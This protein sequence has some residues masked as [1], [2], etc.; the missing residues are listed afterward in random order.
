MKH[1]N[2]WNSCH[3]SLAIFGMKLCVK[4]VDHASLERLDQVEQCG[5]GRD[6]R[7]CFRRLTLTLILLSY[8]TLVGG[9]VP[10]KNPYEA[11]LSNIPSHLKFT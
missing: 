8:V 3:L 4:R 11:S 7:A 5:R 10:A 1:I 9:R 2:T 6:D